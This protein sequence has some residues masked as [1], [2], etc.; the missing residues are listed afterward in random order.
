MVHH[1]QNLEGRLGNIQTANTNED[2]HLLEIEKEA[3]LK[4]NITFRNWEDS[5][6]NANEDVDGKKAFSREVQLAE[7]SKYDEYEELA[8]KLA[9]DITK[10]FYE[11]S[12]ETNKP[13]KLQDTIADKINGKTF[14]FELEVKLQFS[15]KVKDIEA[16][17]YA[18]TDKDEG[19][20]DYKDDDLIQVEIHINP[21]LNKKYQIIEL[22]LFHILV[23]EI[24]HLV[25]GEGINR[26]NDKFIDE[27]PS[28]RALINQG[29][30]GDEEVADT[31]YKILPREIASGVKELAARAK[32]TGNS[33]DEEVEEELDKA[34]ITTP[35]Y[36]RQVKREYKKYITKNNID[37]EINV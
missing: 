6:K 5:I 2:D 32:A 12:E 31:E 27:H 21:N 24:E 18:V 28:I 1:I 25:H 26:V 22:A 7:D 16:Q 20:D 35:K 11:Y 23:H 37:L 15:K 29:A 19:D 9:E 13:F 34:G 8:S 33:F 17:A 4:G 3:Y 10:A 30:F 14:N 36:R